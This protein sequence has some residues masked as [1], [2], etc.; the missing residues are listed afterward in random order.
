MLDNPHGSETPV[1]GGGQGHNAAPAG[2]DKRP[3]TEPE[4]GSTT[5]LEEKPAG[6]D[7]AVEPAE[8]AQ[9]KLLR[10]LGIL[11]GVLAI[12]TFLGIANY[13]QLASAL[14]WHGSS[15]SSPPRD[16][17]DSGVCALARADV[18]KTN[19][20]APADVAAKFG[21][22]FDQSTAFETLSSKAENGTLSRYI[23]AVYLNLVDLDEDLANVEEG[24][25]GNVQQ[26]I[27]NTT[28]SLSRSE[29][30][31]E[32]WCLAHTGVS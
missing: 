6:A 15:T 31:V 18:A 22:Y 25:G 23:D 24:T 16:S 8:D 10:W 30:A 9:K 3:R 17:A 13:H 20:D 32:S 4:S 19:I 14:G 26:K 7:G 28:A 21:F 2:N 29:E 12:L 5:G 11:A 27:A 1:G